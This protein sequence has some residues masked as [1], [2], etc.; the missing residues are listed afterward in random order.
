MNY[1]YYHHLLRVFP[2]FQLEKESYEDLKSA[3]EEEPASHK[4][5]HMSIGMSI[6]DQS[7]SPSIMDTYLKCLRL[8]LA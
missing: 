8:D 1:F 6:A 3:L 4:H 7:V 5:V 2:S